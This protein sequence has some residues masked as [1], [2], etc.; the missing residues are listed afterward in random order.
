MLIH[1][2]SHNTHH[3]KREGGK[4]TFKDHNLWEEKWNK[5]EGKIHMS[6]KEK[7]DCISRED[8]EIRERKW[9]WSCRK[10]K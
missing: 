8:K 10:K 5:R 3:R 2:L 1:T 9:D 4:D 7:E 6:E